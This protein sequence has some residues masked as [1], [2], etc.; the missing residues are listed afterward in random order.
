MDTRVQ[1]GKERMG[2]T[3]KVALTHIHTIVCKKR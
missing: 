3:E 1:A 2:Q